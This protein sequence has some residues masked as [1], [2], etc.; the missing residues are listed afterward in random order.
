MH[1][2]SRKIHCAHLDTVESVLSELDVVGGGAAALVLVG[3]NVGAEALQVAQAVPRHHY[4]GA[5]P[6]Y[7]LNKGINGLLALRCGFI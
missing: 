5:L 4:V 6:L 1:A 7:Q 3:G 2:T